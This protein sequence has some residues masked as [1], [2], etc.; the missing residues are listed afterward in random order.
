MYIVIDMK[1]Y[2]KHKLQNLINVSK[3]ITI[4]YFEFDKDF[5]SDGESH[6]FWELVYAENESIICTAEQTEIKLEPKEI[7]FH[8][9]NEYHILSA[10]GETA[11]NVLIISFACN[12]AAMRFFENK[13]LRLSD[14]Q[15]ALL[16]KIL[17]YGKKTFDIP[18]SDPKLKKM[19]ILPYAT[20][21]GLQMIKNYLEILL[22]DLITSQTEDNGKNDVFVRINVENSVSVEIVVNYLKKNI[23]RN[24]TIDEIA[25]NVY[26]GKSYLMRNFKVKTGKTVMQ[27]FNEL[28]IE[29]AKKLLRESK[30]PISQISENLGFGEPNYFSRVFKKITGFTP[31]Q[32]KKHSK[33]F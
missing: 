6:D 30:L 21:G 27:Y 10:N 8:K 22:I 12:S 23:G 14:S 9:P 13:K 11:P 29:E 28:K 24:L 20:L 1:K 32:Y 5:I 18:Y 3:I 16:Y 26:Y 2:F 33:G 19:E 17:H 25:K 15:A 31:L 4:H 7:L